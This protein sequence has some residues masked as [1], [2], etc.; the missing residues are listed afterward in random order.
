[1]IKR[2]IIAILI[3]GLFVSPS[4]SNE[5]RQKNIGNSDGLSNSAVICVY[6]DS[7]GYVWMGT[8][9]GLNR[10]DGSDIQ[11]Y[12]PNVFQEGNISNNIVR[13]I[14]EDKHNNLW[15]VT[16]DGINKFNYKTE[17]FTSYLTEINDYEYREARFKA[18]LDMDSLL[19][20]SIDG[21]GLFK[22]EDLTDS[23]IQTPFSKSNP[24][25]FD[26]VSNVAYFNDSFWLLTGSGSIFQI[27]SEEMKKKMVYQIPNSTRLNYNQSWMFQKN[28]EIIVYIPIENGGLFSINPE[29]GE[30]YELFPDESKFNVTSLSK[31]LDESFLWGGTDDGQI[32]KLFLNDRKIE[33]H[34][35]TSIHFTNQKIKIW[36]VTETKPDLLWVGTDGNGVYRFIM[37]NNFFSSISKGALKDGKLNH[38]IVRAI[39]E[40]KKENLWVGTRG[41]GIS[42][43][44]MKARTTK[45]INSNDGLSNDAV[46]ALEED[47]YRNMWVG[48]DS[49]GIDMVEYGTGKILHFPEDFS[50]KVD[51]E[52][53][54]VYDI[55]F[56]SYGDIWLGTSGYGL[57]RLNIEKIEDGNYVLKSY[58]LYNSDNS[59][60]KSSI[61]YSIKEGK[62]NIM[63][64]GTR[65]S[66]LYR[67]N[68]LTGNFSALT[69]NPNNINSINNNDIL[70]LHKSENQVLW[71]GTSG[72]LN[73]MDMSTAPFSFDHYTE[74]EG[75]TN[76]TI[77]AIL[78]DDKNQIWVST[79]KAIVKINH[80]QNSIRNYLKSDGLKNSEFTDGAAT[81][82]ENSGLFYFGGVD[83]LDFFKPLE[84]KDSEYFPRL[85]ITD[86]SLLNMEKENPEYIV[87][88]DIDKADSLTF[89]YYQNFFKFS[90]TA[91]NYHNKEKIQYAYSLKGIDN[92]FRIEDRG[93]EATF[94]NIPPG[95]YCF[96]ID[97]TNENGIWHSKKRKI[98]ITVL[99]PF[100][101]TT[102][103]YIIYGFI[104]LGMM[105][106]LIYFIRKRL[107]TR[108][109]ITID[110]LEFEKIKEMNQYKF[111]FFTNIAHEF[112]TPLTLIMA[113]VAKLLDI[114]EN[115]PE[116]Q[117]YL[118][119]VYNNSTRLLHLIRELID[120]RKVETGK[121]SLKVN[122][123]NLT[124]FFN[125]IH[126]AFEQYARQKDIELKLIKPDEPIY[127]W[128]DNRILEKI[129]LN[130]ISNAIKYSYK[131]GEVIVKLEVQSDHV[132]IM[133]KDTGMGVSEK[134]QNKI[135]DRFFHQ[136]ENSLTGKG[137]TDSAGVGLSLT[138]SLVEL[139][140]GNIN[141]ESIP[142]QGSI[143]T[144]SFPVSSS[145]YSEEEKST[146]MVIDEAQIKDRAEEEFIGE[147]EISFPASTSNQTSV[148]T[149]DTILVVDDNEQI[150]NLIAD[151]LYPEYSIRTANNGVE[152]LKCLNDNDI[153]MI[154][155]DV[156]MPEMDGLTLS[157]KI[158]EN[159]VTSHL[160]VILLT[161]KGELEHRIEGIESGADSYIP[162][163]FDPRHLK[164]RVKKLIENR[165]KLQSYFQNNGFK[166]KESL[167]GLNSRDAEFVKKV[168]DFI[169]NN[170]DNED[171]DA[172][173]LVGEVLISKTQLYRKVKALT[174]FTPHGLIKNIR[175]K[176]ASDLLHNSDLT[177][178]E[179]IYETGFKNRTYFY[180]SFKE[181]YGDS[182][183]DHA[184]KKR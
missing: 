4:Q 161:A 113:P 167:N 84:V 79:N 9:D 118:K 51:L 138:K 8:W 37:K 92:E 34:K 64:V 14:F 152:A 176:K 102:W 78:E 130:L 20:C 75:L 26:E 178:S 23:F 125:T 94:T 30:S 122:Y 2:L 93:S 129:M 6:M 126:A 43:V 35:E 13:D 58:N 16:E 163:P 115:D 99:P 67:L 168:S 157:R 166:D 56:D 169:E 38:N 5:W 63:W 48:V 147:D 97:W 21:H 17:K 108:H 15:V 12:K 128:F 173:D 141:L 50:N 127:G 179:I 158:K 104:F 69:S 144:I 151:I 62:P 164:V 184:K 45:V 181:L 124:S 170:I 24:D 109:K 148:E 1:M 59:G 19:Y 98:H 27:S 90:F 153:S 159:P 71:I 172:D 81:Y 41:G 155:T 134:Y 72:G 142:Q 25:L 80:K 68:R 101:Q 82:G 136:S 3:A 53:G 112:R 156:I 139:H 87:N 70:S 146:G 61:V 65:G 31:S 116:V 137:R 131:D 103:A 60:L 121:F 107:K 7:R 77:H 46:L 39:H 135:F 10:Y 162:K 175:L 49:E 110:R 106:S 177:V 105:L 183:L 111:Q 55:V 54:Y 28:S 36:S 83:G 74:K 182:P 76:N 132:L 160:P 123:D 57:L 73:R 171:L 66:G 149:S 18:F 133:V 145:F 165:N 174:G 180:R 85:A 100:W 47:S 32:F 29:K 86:F 22:Y 117:P 95:E 52:F 150:R 140:K 154:I 40:D 114:K 96:T 89:K 11:I 143:F 88:Q 120:F 42:I 91:L 119:S 33:I 44:S